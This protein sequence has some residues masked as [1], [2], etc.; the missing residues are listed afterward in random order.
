VWS[1]VLGPE[2]GSAGRL[3][4]RLTSQNCSLYGPIV[5]PRVIAMLTMVWWY[6]LGLTPNSF[7][8]ALWQPPVLSGGIVSRDT[9]GASR[10]T[11]EGNENLVYP[12]T[13]D[14][15]RFL[16][17]HKI[18]RHGTSG[19]TSHP[20]KVVLRIFIA[21]QNPSTWPGS[22]PLTL[23]PVASTLTTTPPRWLSVSG[24]WEL[25]CKELH[26]LYCSP[27]I[28]KMNKSM[29]MRWAGHIKFI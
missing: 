11:G 23:G 15:N 27:N 12:S 24:C 25:H 16:T 26:N 1:G 18:L 21:L 5:R 19:F 9:S 3:R 10:R 13:W 17:C 29:T 28:I 20:K 4:V 6:L 2:G 14:F 22:N 8:R 7:T